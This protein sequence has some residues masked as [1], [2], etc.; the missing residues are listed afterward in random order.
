LDAA[1]VV[2]GEVQAESPTQWFSHFL[3]KPFIKR[4]MLTG[5]APTGGGTLPH[6]PETLHRRHA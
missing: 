5:S 4:I 2:V 3:E 6:L 1:K